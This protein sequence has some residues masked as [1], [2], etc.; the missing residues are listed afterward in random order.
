[1]SIKIINNVPYIGCQDIYFYKITKD[2]ETGYT[3]D[4]ETMLKVPELEQVA[5]NPNAT[6]SAF[7]S[8]NV[9]KITDTTYAPSAAFTLSGDCEELETFLFNKVKSG[10]AILDNL[11]QNAQIGMFYAQNKAGG[12]WIIRQILKCTC[13]KAER[14]VDTKGENIS[15]QTAATNVN[16]LYCNHFKSYVREFFSEDEKFTGKTLDDVLAA[17]AANPSEDFNTWPQ[18]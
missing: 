8:N 16:P 14:N 18:S 12:A 2:D 5:Y 13:S 11:G 7:Y 3:A 1:M 15:F 4:A 6:D 10:A 17:L 9:K